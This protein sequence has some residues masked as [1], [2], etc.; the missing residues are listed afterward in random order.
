MIL[1]PYDSAYFLKSNELIS[2]YLTLAQEDPDPDTYAAALVTVA[3][4]R[5]M[6]GLLPEGDGL[7][8]KLD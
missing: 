2:I 8:S 7:S 5:E 1:T 4:A 3:R 6:H